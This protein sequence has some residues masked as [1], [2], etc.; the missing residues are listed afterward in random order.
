MSQHKY[1]V[2]QHVYYQPS[3]RYAAQRGI[4]TIVG[5]FPDGYR[6]KHSAETCERAAKENEL[7][8][9]PTA[10]DAEPL[11]MSQGTVMRHGKW[12]K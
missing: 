8:A 3:I 9:A 1:A 12:G 7:A 10:D 2:G 5:L 11:V 6:I 4:Y